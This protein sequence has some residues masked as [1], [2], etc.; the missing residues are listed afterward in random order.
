MSFVVQV[1]GAVPVMAVDAPPTPWGIALALV[2]VGWLIGHHSV[3]QVGMWFCGLA[4]ALTV[5]RDNR[6]TRHVVRASVRIEDSVRS[7]R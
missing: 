4:V 6:K 1:K 5:V 7:V 3:G 2:A